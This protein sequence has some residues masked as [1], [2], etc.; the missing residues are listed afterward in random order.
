MMSTSTPVVTKLREHILD[1][2]DI[3][4]GWDTDDSVANLTQQLRS[5]TYPGHNNIPAARDLVEGGT[6]LAYYADVIEFLNKLG[7]ND[8]KNTKNYTDRQ[9]WDLYV[10]LLVREILNLTEDE[11]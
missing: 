2:F 7:L 11:K 10:N 6:F 8:R 1:Q 4:H 3:D 9:S 5:M